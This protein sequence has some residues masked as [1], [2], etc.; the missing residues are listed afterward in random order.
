MILEICKAFAARSRGIWA[1]LIR[2]EERRQAV[3]THREDRLRDVELEQARNAGTKSIIE[4]LSN[5]GNIV[6]I[7]PGGRSRMVWMPERPLPPTIHWVITDREERRNLDDPPQHGE[8]I[9]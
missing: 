1:Y 7:E 8:L 4:A 5:G 3:E 2:R 9:R 6:E